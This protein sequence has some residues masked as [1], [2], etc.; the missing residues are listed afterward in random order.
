MRS[1]KLSRSN[2]KKLIIGM[3]MILG[4]TMSVNAQIDDLPGDGTVDDAPAAPIDG[5]VAIG[6]LA[7][8]AIG[9]RHK[10]KK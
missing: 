2:S 5:I 7:A 6:F 9:M 8:A 1:I 4:G 10:M 3:M